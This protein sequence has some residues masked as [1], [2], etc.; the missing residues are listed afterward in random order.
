MISA[1]R[2]DGPRW[3]SYLEKLDLN[4]ISNLIKNGMWFDDNWI[5]AY[6]QKEK[7]VLLLLMCKLRTMSITKTIAKKTQTDGKL[8]NQLLDCTN[9]NSTATIIPYSCKK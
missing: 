5:L 9:T 7:N 2:S 3:G 8:H 4:Y 6:P 1:Q